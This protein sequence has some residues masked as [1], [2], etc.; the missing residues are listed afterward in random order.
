MKQGSPNETVI[1]LHGIVPSPG[2]LK[3]L[4]RRLEELGYQTLNLQY[5]SAHWSMAD[6]AEAVAEDTAALAASSEGPIHYVGYSM[7]GL[8]ARMAVALSRPR[9][10]GRMVMIA[11]PNAGSEVADVMAKTPLMR[12]A[13]G[14][15]SVELTRKGAGEITQRLGAPDYDVGVIAGNRTLQVF[16]SLLMPWP[17]DGRVSVEAT[18]LKGMADHAVVK[19]SHPMIAR[20]P[21]AISL[22]CRFLATGRFA[23]VT[24]RRSEG[25]GPT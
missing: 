24:T 15:A 8:V 9:N 3:P 6:C 19:S 17:N 25:A 5:P 7:G 10:M 14:P 11:S 1:L 18:K 12:L 4:Q 22:T 21:E 23:P 16:A 2:T 20:N 13:Y